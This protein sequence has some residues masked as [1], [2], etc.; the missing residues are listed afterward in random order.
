MVRR[1]YRRSRR[2]SPAVVALVALMSAALAACTSVAPDPDSQS[3]GR[4]GQ[5]GTAAGP[6]FTVATTSQQLE[7]G[8]AEL[9][10][11]TEPELMVAWAPIGHPGAVQVLGSSDTLD[12]WSTIKVPIALAAVQKAGGDLPAQA[13]QDLSASLT[14]SNNDAASRLFKGLQAY[15]DPASVVGQ[16]L[17]SAGDTSTQ[18]D[19]SAFGLTHWGVADSARFA[20]ALPCEPYADK[21]LSAM[22]NIVAD[23]RWGLGTV[24]G[25]VYKGGWGDSS[26][27]YLVRQVGIIRD[28]A[29]VGVG[30]SLLTQP[31]DRTHATGTAVL[32]EAARWLQQH[33]VAGD[34][35]ACPA[36]PGSAGSPS[37]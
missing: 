19:G 15:G 3:G 29:G 27:G 35:A 16:V 36:A 11:R 26:D 10:A 23:Q 31:A 34:T 22:E 5:R 17:A 1:T 37:P 9:V 14:R 25:S 6:T 18:V 24:E 33:L 12:A 8:F 20:A 28:P 13:V 30:V 32:G 4:A 2:G 21:V 7:P